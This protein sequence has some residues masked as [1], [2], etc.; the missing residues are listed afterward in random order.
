MTP[1][2]SPKSLRFSVSKAH[3]TQILLSKKI[4]RQDVLPENLDLVAGVDIAYA[5]EVCVGAVA[6]LD[7]DSLKLQEAQTATCKVRFPYIPTLLSFREIPPAIAAIR[8][9]NL[10]PDVFLVDAHGI[11]H[12]YRLGFASHLGLV[13]GKP[14]IGVA[15]SRLVGKPTEMGKDV[16]LI[17]EGEVVGMVVTT[18]KGVKPIYVSIGNKVSLETAVTI[19]KHCVYG[20][21]LP[22][23]TSVAHKLASETRNKLLDGPQKI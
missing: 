19:V 7:Y 2:L 10:H 4:L 3:R 6:V 23:P 9:L 17:H 22:E 12:P 21:R 13:L 16:F 14:T 5:S 8:K 15:K 1:T 18:I 20:G 11:A